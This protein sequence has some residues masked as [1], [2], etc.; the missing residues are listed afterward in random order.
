MIPS[1]ILAIE[2]DADREFMTWL[3]KQYQRLM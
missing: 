2:D 3:Y 1:I